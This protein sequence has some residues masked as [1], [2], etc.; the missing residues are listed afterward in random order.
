MTHPVPNARRSV[1][2]VQKTKPQS[3]LLGPRIPDRMAGESLPES[4]FFQGSSLDHGA[5]SITY[6][7]PGGGGNPTQLIGLVHDVSS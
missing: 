1:A 5:S 6:W 2:V 4:F 7:Q 3:I